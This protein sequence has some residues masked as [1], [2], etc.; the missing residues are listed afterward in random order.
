MTP[1]CLHG[2]ELNLGNDRTTTTIKDCKSAKKNWV[3]KIARLTKADRRIVV[4]LRDGSAEELDRYSCEEQTGQD[5][6]TGWRM[7][8]YRRERRGGQGETREAKA[9]MGGWKGRQERRKTGRRR[10]ETEE[11]GKDYQMRR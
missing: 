4:E 5:M 1:A 7:T 3:R 11:G 6:E 9:D 8:D 10:Q 2:T